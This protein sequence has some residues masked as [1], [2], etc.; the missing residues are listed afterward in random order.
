MVQHCPGKKSVR[1]DESADRQI[2]TVERFA[3]KNDRLDLVARLQHLQRVGGDRRNAFVSGTAI[4]ASDAY[5]TFNALL[6]RKPVKKIGFLSFGHWTT[7]PH[8][9][10]RSGLSP[11]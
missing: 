1:R 9:Q 4:Y 2:L 10:T 8:S 11:F 6:L 5:E 3:T 7:S